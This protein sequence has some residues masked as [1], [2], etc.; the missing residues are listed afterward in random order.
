[1]RTFLAC[2][3]VPDAIA[4]LVFAL[5]LAGC[6]STPAR[7]DAASLEC[8]QLP[9]EIART[10][11]ARRAA[12]EGQQDAWKLVLAPVVVARFAMGVSEV[13]ENNKRLSE[14]RA[15]FKSKECT[16]LG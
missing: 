3:R 5:L 4:P 9:A 2:L 11:M 10:E 16:K 6:A 14:L 8:K 13:S 12:L 15:Q 1:M 7:P